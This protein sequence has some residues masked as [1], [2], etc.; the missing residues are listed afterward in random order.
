MSETEGANGNFFNEANTNKKL[1][2]DI[3]QTFQDQSPPKSIMP[4]LQ[5]FSLSYSGLK[6]LSPIKQPDFSKPFES[7]FRLYTKK[8]TAEY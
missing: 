7:G 3:L 1:K 5:N 2:K 6:N 8:N 4:N